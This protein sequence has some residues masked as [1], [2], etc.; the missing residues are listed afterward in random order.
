MDTIETDHLVDD[1]LRRL[2]HAASRTQRARRTELVAEIRGHIET[3][4]SQEQAANEA[5]VRNVLDR[6]GSPEDIV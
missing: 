3:A 2:E 5:A 4:V 1:C 6:L